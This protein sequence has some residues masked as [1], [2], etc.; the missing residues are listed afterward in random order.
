M[1][2]VAV[3]DYLKCQPAKC[4][5]LCQRVCPGVR[6]GD[7]TII[8]N[9][10]T[11]Q[12]IISESLCTGC[13]ICPKKCPFG[14]II[15][16]NTPEELDNPLFQYGENSFRLF[17]IPDPKPGVVGIVGPNGIGK[18]TAL[19]ILAGELK[20]NLGDWKKEIEW[21][22]I[23]EQFRGQE[24]QNF[25]KELAEKKIKVSYKPQEVEKIASLAKG[26]VRDLLEKVDERKK[27]ME[28]IKLL[29]MEK[30]LDSEISNLS[31]GEL[32][33]VAIIAAIVKEADIYT[34]DEPTSYLDIKQRLNIAKLLRE[35]V[36]QGKR[37]IVIEHDL[38]VLDYLSD[39][40][41]VLYGTEGAF[42]VVSHSKPINTGINQFLDGYLPDENVRIRNYEITFAVTSAQKMKEHKKLLDYPAMKKTFDRFSLETEEG[43]L[44]QTE[45]LGIMGPN[46]IGKTTF[47]KLLAGEID[48][49][50]GKFATKMKISYKPQYIDLK[51]DGTVKELF[52][53]PGLDKDHYKSELE[54]PLNLKPFYDQYLHE[55]SGGELQRVAVAYA[56]SK[57][58]Q[59]YLL[60]EPSAFLDVLQ[61]LEVAKA[62]RRITQKREA[63]AIVVDHDLIFQD[64]VADRLLVFDGAPAEK[65][66]AKTP[67][68]KQKGMNSFLKVMGITFRRDVKSGRPRANKP[69]SQKDIEQKKT[70]EYFYL[71]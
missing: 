37:I 18:S 68:D 36:E 71:K 8:I 26:K 30:V 46:G 33:R 52:E 38:A 65:G 17:R 2:R 63:V 62:I 67:Q 60:D 3:I 20:P 42:G 29:D 55:L 54:G 6:M 13:G 57:K 9:P 14:A 59:I 15:I 47:V 66:Y 50:E 40:V 61:R 70:G 43:H 44:N 24:L 21:K 49:D 69:N 11:H 58:A 28:Y 7:E 22:D 48:P 23:V 10:A 5:H 41:H 39:Y 27:A 45:V 19:K 4:N 51:F 1:V 35:M 12:P 64:Y 31:G 34:L 32:Q 16:V 56:L 25:L 53:H